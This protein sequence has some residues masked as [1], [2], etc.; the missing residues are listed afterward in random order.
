MTKVSETRAG[1]NNAKWWDVFLAL[2]GVRTSIHRVIHARRGWLFTGFL[3]CT[4]AL[5]REYDGISLLHQ[6]ADLLGSFAASLLLSSVLF[7]WFWAGLNACKIRLVGPWKHAVVFLTGYWLTAPLAW[8]YAV[9]VE[10]MTDEVTALRYNLTALSVVSIWRVLLFAR[11]TSIQFRIPFAVSLFWIL[12]PC[13]VIAFFALIN[14]IM[15]MVSIMG[16]IRLTTTQQMIVDFQGVILG[17]VW[18]SFLPVVIAAIALTVW[19]RRKGGGRRVARTLPN[20]SAASWAIPLA[21]LGVLIVGAIRF[22]PA[23][24]LAHQVDAK[25]LDGSIADAIAMMDQH[26]EGDFPRTWDPQPQYSM[27]TES[28]PS[29]GEIS[30]ALRNEQPASW[31]VDRMMVQADE[32]ILRQAGYWGGAEGTLSRREPMFY[33]DVDTIRRLIEDLENTAGLPIADQALA[34]RLK[35]LQAIAQE[36]LQPAIDRDADMER[37][38]GEMAVE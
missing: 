24:S 23:L 13:M 11:V 20:V 19:M 14:S 35:G 15:S 30:K 28:K 29:I 10:S 9:P 5:G 7:L 1:S 17:G 8:I 38:M 22:Q 32:I 33:L 26:N 27:R 21:V 18:W 31:V 25:L 12:V 4:A 16:G 6:P 36:S 3:V 37:A 2:V 34:E